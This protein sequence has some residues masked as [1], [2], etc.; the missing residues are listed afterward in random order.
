MKARRRTSASPARVVA[1]PPAATLVR[2]AELPWFPFMSEGVHLKLCRV[3]LATGEMVLMVRAAPGAALAT[4]YR[5]GVFIAY[6]L[7]GQW[8]YPDH[9]W[10]AG[11][12][13]VVVEPAGSTHA[14]EVVGDGPAEAFVH[15]AGALEF[16]DEDGK[17]LCIENAETLHGR[18]LA[19]CALHGIEPVDVTGG[20]PG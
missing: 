10:I 5:H 7:S 12:G 15:L 20:F 18:Y 17:T 3:S 8:R 16:R 1:P 4:H 2:S 14:F 13:D 11:P 19:H 9:G 6:T